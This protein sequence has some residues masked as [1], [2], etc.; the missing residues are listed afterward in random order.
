MRVICNNYRFSHLAVAAGQVCW[1]GLQGASLSQ[2]TALDTEARANSGA[3]GMDGNGPGV[4]RRHYFCV[5]PGGVALGAL[6]DYQCV[7][8]FGVC[9]ERG[10]RQQRCP[11]D[12][13]VIVETKMRGQNLPRQRNDCECVSFVIMTESSNLM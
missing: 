13:S 1:N 6:G 7:A 10:L 2:I 5:V 8:W 9:I 11:L 12:S 3:L 4:A